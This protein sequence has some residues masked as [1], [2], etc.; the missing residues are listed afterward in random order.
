MIPGMPPGG[1]PPGPPPDMGPGGPPMGPGGPPGGLDPNVLMAL[2]AGGPGG[3]PGL[4]GPGGP[5]P[6]QGP[7]DQGGDPVDILQK[8]L[9]LYQQ[10]M[11]VEPD[12]E[13]KAVAAD[14][15]AKIQKLLAKNQAQAD[16]AMG[17][18]PAHKFMRK[19]NALA[20]P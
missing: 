14:C 4:G 10:Y 1:P 20:G 9:D 2:M 16:A 12:E 5:P 13:D 6:D 19:A 11:Q 15:G 18:T 3:P 8:M 17:T 7:P